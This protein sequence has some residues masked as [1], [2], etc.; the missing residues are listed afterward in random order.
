MKRLVISLILLIGCIFPHIAY[1][2]SV[3]Q[4]TIYEET[5]VVADE[6]GAWF[7]F[8][9]RAADWVFDLVATE[10]SGTGTLDVDI[11]T[12]ADKSHIS[13]SILSFTQLS[14]TGDEFKTLAAQ[15]FVIKCIRA[16]IDVGA[17]CS[18]N[19]DITVKAHYRRAM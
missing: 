16:V 4:T 1:A 18:P 3:N 10:N 15:T 13:T 12:T 6:N 17:A 19:S 11:V 14:A 2:G 8:D 7:C 9:N 5:A